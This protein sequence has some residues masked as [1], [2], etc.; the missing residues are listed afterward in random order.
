MS[1]NNAAAPEVSTTTDAAAA[2]TTATATPSGPSPAKNDNIFANA[3]NHIVKVITPVPDDVNDKRMKGSND[4][5]TTSTK[6]TNPVDAVKEKITD[7]FG[8]FVDAIT[9][10]LNVPL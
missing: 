4:E 5:E 8:I 7:A 6:K 3:I 9:P 10:I 2:A 1:S